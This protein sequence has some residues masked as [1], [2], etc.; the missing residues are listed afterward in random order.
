MPQYAR[1]SDVSVVLPR[2]LS[3]S[4]VTPTS[5]HAPCATVPSSSSSSSVCNA[6]L[7]AA[8]ACARSETAA[9]SS[10]QHTSSKAM[11]LDAAV[12]RYRIKPMAFP[13]SV[14][15]GMDLIAMRF[16]DGKLPIVLRKQ[17]AIC[18]EDPRPRRVPSAVCV[19]PNVMLS[20]CRGANWNGA[21]AAK[22]TK[23][24]MYSNTGS[25][26]RSRTRIESAST[27]PLY[28]LRIPSAFPCLPR[29][30]TRGRFLSAQ[31]MVIALFA[32]VELRDDILDKSLIPAGSCVLSRVKSIT[33]HGC[34]ARSLHVAAR[35]P[36]ER[37]S[38]YIIQEC[39]I[40]SGSACIAM[41]SVK[42]TVCSVS[43]DVDSVSTMLLYHTAHTFVGAP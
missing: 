29:R 2:R 21:L 31:C 20:K 37:T 26:P 35:R 22:N 5:P 3:T 8:S 19:P 11:H 30:N 7:L 1:R 14:G 16:M 41:I 18:S 9:A 12:A 32:G 42:P 13:A 28:K 6:V 43:C 36:R 25:T 34:A 38:M 17:D 24:L 33:G 15:N 39:H 4:A 10:S 40:S 23:L 27:M